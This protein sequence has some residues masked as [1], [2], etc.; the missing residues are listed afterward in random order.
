MPIDAMH[1]MN[2]P[3]GTLAWKETGRGAPLILLHGWSMSHAVFAE[4]SSYIQAG[5]RLLIPD[6]PGHGQSSSVEPCTLENYADQLV[7]WLNKLGLTQI[8][9]LGWSLGGQLAMRL[10]ID[11]PELVNRLVLI[12]T[13]PR[14]CA[15]EGWSAGLAAGE[16]RVLKR[17]LPQHYRSTMGTFFDRQ[18]GAGEISA[19]RRL[20]IL[21][22]AV[23]PVGLPQPESACR[24]LD[25]L[26]QEDLR[27]ILDRIVVPTLIIHGREDQI[28][29]VAA[30]REL[31]LRLA[32]AHLVTL[33]GCGHAPFLSQ[34]QA[35][36][37]ILREFLRDPQ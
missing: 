32:Q 24:T 10:A 19:A 18:F 6:L 17:G 7:Y 35:V 20:E 21:R 26:G 9:V 12:S 27:E 30:G 31:A 14:F 22:F 13:T 1:S 16:L 36:A 37:D 3:C 11:R 4:F 5:Y 8:S 34:P 29:P 25:I 23:R 2:T 15:G 33:E 28:I